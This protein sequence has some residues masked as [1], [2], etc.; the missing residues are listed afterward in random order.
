MGAEPVDRLGVDP[1]DRPLAGGE[2]VEALDLVGGVVLR[3][4]A[5]GPVP[6]RRGPDRTEK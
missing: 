1:L 5:E 2:R 3:A 4:E 6:P